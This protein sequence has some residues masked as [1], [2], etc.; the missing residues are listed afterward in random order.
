M[1][2]EVGQDQG[3]VRLCQPQSRTTK[4]AIAE[5]ER[6]EIKHNSCFMLRSNHPEERAIVTSWLSKR[7]TEIRERAN[8]KDVRVDMH[9]PD[10]GKKE[11]P[12]MQRQRFRARNKT[13]RK[14]IV[15]V[16]AFTPLALDVPHVAHLST[17]YRLPHP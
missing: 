9:K 5:F 16:C 7:K 6:F 10:G 13:I 4:I 15:I 2:S 3:D 11:R 17:R 14:T 12:S 8:A 1:I